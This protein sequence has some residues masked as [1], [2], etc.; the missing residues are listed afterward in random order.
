MGFGQRSE[1]ICEGL[2]GE[3]IILSDDAY[4]FS[5]GLLLASLF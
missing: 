3:E 5:C 4:H 2:Q 1:G